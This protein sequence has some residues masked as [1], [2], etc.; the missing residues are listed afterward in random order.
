MIAESFLKAPK[1][2]IK[3]KEM[4]AHMPIPR[5]Y[6]QISGATNPTNPAKSFQ[7]KK[8]DSISKGVDNWKVKNPD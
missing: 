7:S 2:N 1:P 5:I 4:A 8:D 3:A 6:E